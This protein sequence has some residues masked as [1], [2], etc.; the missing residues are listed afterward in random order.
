MLDEFAE[1]VRQACAAENVRLLS[2]EINS[3]GI[4]DSGIMAF[5][6]HEQLLRVLLKSDSG[7][8]ASKLKDILLD[9]TSSSLE[10]L[11]GTPLDVRARLANAY[12]AGGVV[13]LVVRWFQEDI[14][15]DEV[16][17]AFAVMQIPVSETLRRTVGILTAEEALQARVAELED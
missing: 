14:P 10:K 2:G 7:V 16:K 8:F 5:R 4:A 9:V 1:T 12:A 13:A 3:D 17:H 6:K 11:T 15:F